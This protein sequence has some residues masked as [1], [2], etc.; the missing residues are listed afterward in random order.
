MM[1]SR[2]AQLGHRFRGYAQQ[3]A[4]HS[5]VRQPDTVTSGASGTGSGASAT[6][7]GV[8]E[9]APVPPAAPA[10]E[11][12]VAAPAP[13]MAPAKAALA[14][15]VQCVVRGWCGQGTFACSWCKRAMA[16]HLP[17]TATIGSRAA[18][19]GHRFRGYDQ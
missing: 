6:S 1:G 16:H 17:A 12:A 7:G 13:P 2:A 4:A 14:E 11:A 10:K 18:Q 5:D 19:I 15:L 8:A 3:A 9:A